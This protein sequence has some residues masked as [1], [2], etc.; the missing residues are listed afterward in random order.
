MAEAVRSVLGREGTLLVEAGTGTGKTL[1]YLVPA[2]LS[3]KKVVIS[4]GT[5][6]LQEQI[7]HKDLPLI[8]K[9][10]GLPVRAAC[11]KGLGNY[12]CLRRLREAFAA[13]RDPSLAAIARWAQGTR[14]G[15]RADLE[16]VSDDDPVWNDV[17][18][19]SE[20]RIGAKCDHFDDCF[21]TRMRRQAEAAELVIVNHHL[22]FADLAIRGPHGQGVIPEHDAVVLDEAHKI[23]DV[24]TDFFSLR[25]S[26]RRIES[27]VGDTRRSLATPRAEVPLGDLHPVLDHLTLSAALFFGALPDGPESVT[28]T[29]EMVES[30]DLVGRHHDLDD[31]LEALGGALRRLEAATGSE[32]LA[33]AA[34]RASDLR[35]D[36]AAILTDRGQTLVRYV[37]R[38]GRNVAVAAAPI[39]LSEILKE[40]L[41]YSVPSVVLASATL[42][43]SGD[44]RFVRQRLG[45]DFDADEL[46]V[47]SPFDY[48]SQAMLYTP[49]GLPEPRDPD[50]LAR[51]ADEVDRLVELTGGGA[52]VLCTSFRAMRALHGALSGRLSAPCLLQG[53]RPKTALVER[54]R[55]LGDAVLFA[56]ASFWEGIDVPGDALRLVV[57]DKLPFEVPS[58]PVVAA[59]IRHL[60]E[61]GVEAF[62]AYQVPAAALALKQGFGRLIRTRTDRGI[63][64]ILDRRIVTRGYGKVLLGSLPPCARASDLEEVR[65]F[66][67]RKATMEGATLP[68]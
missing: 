27:L 54:F 11:M 29:R 30:P 10:L 58:D 68:E 2:I 57:I 44:F 65:C 55:E 62:A 6:A 31:A 36:L 46:V 48:P 33:L 24:A 66:W 4:T 9:H 34:G 56:T 38:R 63:V 61:H 22:F 59:R 28:L 52:F 51:A 47:G 16:T 5:K 15:D 23:E 13:G 37:Q 43:T 18:S 53:E 17:T 19:S 32:P 26:T 1:A 49:V 7:L 40:K 25:V 39:D 41:F 35:N 12:V 50:F 64:A 21:V 20:T 8:R 60:N 3:G 14:T 67:R 42:A 45:I